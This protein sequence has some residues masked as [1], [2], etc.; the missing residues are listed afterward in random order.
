MC[1]RMCRKKRRKGRKTQSVGERAV[2]GCECALLC[3]AERE[4]KSSVYYVSKRKR[5]G[6][7]TLAS[8]NKMEA[9]YPITAIAFLVPFTGQLIR[10]HA[11]E[12]PFDQGG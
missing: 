7:Y 4:R 3:A 9:G 2:E 8:T 5:M 10:V 1:G 11:I 6:I 12:I